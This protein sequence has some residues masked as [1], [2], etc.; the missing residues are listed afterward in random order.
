M[1]RYKCDIYRG[2]YVT[3]GCSVG[4]AVGGAVLPGSIYPTRQRLAMNDIDEFVEILV[5]LYAVVIALMVVL[6][7]LESTL[8]DQTRPRPGSQRSRLAAS[9]PESADRTYRPWPRFEG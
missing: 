5:A 3:G 8:Y 1:L 6:T 4:F 2:A 7:R 9:D